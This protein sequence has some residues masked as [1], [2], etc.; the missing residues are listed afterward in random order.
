MWTHTLLSSLERV[1]T[2]YALRVIPPTTHFV[3]YHVNSQ[4]CYEISMNWH[5]CEWRGLFEYPGI[6][7][8][9]LRKPLK[10]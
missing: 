9:R 4:V 7:L 8:L 2:H 10:T 1:T 6:R 5:G 3:L